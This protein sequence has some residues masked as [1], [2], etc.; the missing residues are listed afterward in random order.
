MRFYPVRPGIH[1]CF[2]LK[3]NDPV[4]EDREFGG[5]P[6][7]DGPVGPAIRVDG[8]DRDLCAIAGIEEETGIVCGLQVLEGYW[9]KRGGSVNEDSLARNLRS[10]GLPVVGCA[11]AWFDEIRLGFQ[12]PPGVASEKTLGQSQ[13]P[14]AG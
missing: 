5:L 12:L 7:Q 13:L 6:R 3:N 11:P 2:A 10:E 1:S 14:R 8:F 4:T 9:F